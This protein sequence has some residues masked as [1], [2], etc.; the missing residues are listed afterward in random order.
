[1][2]ILKHLEPMHR[3]PQAESDGGRHH[4]C[5]FQHVLSSESES[6]IMPPLQTHVFRHTRRRGQKLQFTCKYITE[7]PHLSHRALHGWLAS[8]SSR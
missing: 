3:L 1:M 7:S 4:N 6:D 2:D 5:H 8:V